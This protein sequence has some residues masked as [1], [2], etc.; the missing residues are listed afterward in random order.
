MAGCLKSGSD[1]VSS[2]SPVVIQYKGRW[3]Q[4]TVWGQ[5]PDALGLSWECS[6]S[7]PCKFEALPLNPQ[8]CAW[9]TY[10][11]CVLNPLLWHSEVYLRK[12]N[13]RVRSGKL[14][15]ITDILLPCYRHRH[16][17][18][19]ERNLFMRYRCVCM[20]ATAVLWRPHWGLETPKSFK[21]TQPCSRGSEIE[22]HMLVQS[23]EPRG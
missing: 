20:E 9:C 19:P 21:F 11:A 2:W 17:S 14:E 10:N 23:T 12:R 7:G 16:R 4:G 18:L 5:M 15:Q 1:K 8:W 22:V 3:R 13:V 6:G